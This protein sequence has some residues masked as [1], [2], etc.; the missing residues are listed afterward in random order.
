MSHGD[1]RE[2]CW[3][4]FIIQTLLAVWHLIHAFPWVLSP[5]TETHIL[6]AKLNAFSAGTTGLK[7]NKYIFL[8]FLY[9]FLI[10]CLQILS[11]KHWFILKWFVDS[12]IFMYVLFQAI[13]ICIKSISVY[14]YYIHIYI[15][16]A[17]YC[18]FVSVLSRRR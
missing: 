6:W 18:I 12:F 16:C 10:L 11:V 4:A 17:L 9:L 13:C 5:Y 2:S 1:T 14:V 15:L 3:A 8:I 7:L